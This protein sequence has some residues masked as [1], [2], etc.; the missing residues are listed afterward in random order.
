MPSDVSPTESSES[1]PQVEV[2]VGPVAH[3]GHCVARLDGRVVFVRHA[4]P[5]ERA[6]VQITEGEQD[7][8]FW[9]GDAVEILEPSPDRVASVWPEAGPGGVGGGELAHVALPAQRR[10]KA[11]VVAEQLQRLAHLDLQ[12][13]V[14]G[15]PGDDERDGLGYRTRIDLV[16]DAEG[17]AGMHKHRS[18]DV[19]ALDTMPL[20]TPEVLALAER[21]RVFTRRWRPGTRLELV[22]PAGGTPP[23]L[24]VDDA[25]W[26]A[27]HLDKRPNARR[28]VVENVSLRG[29][30]HTFKVAADG[31]WQVHRA[32]PLVLGEAVLDAVGDVQGGRVV[33]LYSGAG[34]FSLPLAHAVGDGGHVVAIE[35]DPRAVKDARR[36]A[37]GAPQVELHHGPVERVLARGEHAARGGAD[38]VVLD[39]P[40]TGAGRAVV[41]RVAALGPRSVVYVACDPA[42]LARD[43]AYLAEHG[44][45]LSTLR[46]FDLFP[47]THHVEA[48]AVLT[49]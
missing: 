31:F 27:G 32:A 23:V 8:P 36:N 22:A 42:A 38:V 41:E 5:G 44:Y 4:L 15:L 28:S 35:G 16:A 30:E 39:P 14:E 2:E 18:H 3:G 26:R 6:R 43:V 40:R 13:E 34:L 24:L 49:R 45:T 48:L 47:H 46:A 19:V 29:V 33:D 20:A 9:R 11:G 21:E 17:R 37:H 10:W 12:V 25:V 7:A 1:R